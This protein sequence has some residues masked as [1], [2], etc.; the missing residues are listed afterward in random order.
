MFTINDMVIG[1]KVTF[2]LTVTDVAGLSDMDSVAVTI[3]DDIPPV[4]DAGV[5]FESCEYVKSG[6]NYR[7]YLNGSGSSDIDGTVKF[8]W[9]QLEGIDVDLS[10]SQSKKETPYFNYPSG[11]I[12]EFRC[13]FSIA[14]L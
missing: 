7:V 8:K 10:S 12:G 9:T 3:L 14:C 11:L 5:D 1:E 6:S 4:A 2:Y 13:H